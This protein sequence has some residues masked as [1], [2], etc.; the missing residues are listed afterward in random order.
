QFYRINVVG[1]LLDAHRDGYVERRICA[2]S[3][4]GGR[5]AWIFE[6]E[7]ADI[8]ADQAHA[9]LGSGGLRRCTALGLVGHYGSFSILDVFRQLAGWLAFLPHADKPNRS[10]TV[11]SAPIIV[12][13]LND[14]GIGNAG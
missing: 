14:W 9:R 11:F 13:E 12:V 1:M 6:A 3:H 4:Q 2:R 10:A 7:I 8:L 5:C